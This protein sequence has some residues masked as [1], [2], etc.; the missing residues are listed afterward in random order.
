[1]LKVANPIP[2]YLFF[3]S[4]FFPLFFCSLFFLFFLWNRFSPGPS[5]SRRPLLS[6]GPPSP[7][8]PTSSG[9][10]SRASLSRERRKKRKKYYIKEKKRKRPISFDLFFFSFSSFFFLFC[11]FLFLF[12]APLLSGL[13]PLPDLLSRAPFPG[14][15][16]KR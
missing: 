10:L 4:C 3:F 6:L 9:P 5:I 7:V 15:G 8:A 12:L 13:R 2:F 16:E 11:F 14:K 1:M